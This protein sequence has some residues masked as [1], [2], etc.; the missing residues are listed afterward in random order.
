MSVPDGFARATSLSELE[1]GRMIGVE[2]FGDRVCVARLGDEIYALEDRCTHSL[3]PLSRG[4]LHADGTVEC[5]W[6]GA[7]FDCRT[8][9]PCRG[10]ASL[11]VPTFDVLLHDGDVYVR[12]RQS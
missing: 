1:P 4:E 9:A 10:P 11:D 5:A 6:H 2:L 12:P 3:F 7:R 8:G